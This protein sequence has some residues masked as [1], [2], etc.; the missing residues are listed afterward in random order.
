VRALAA[1]RRWWLRFAYRRAGIGVVNRRLL[2]A[3][4]CEV[5]LREYGAV[6]GDNC[7]VHGPLV[8]HNAGEDYR[9]LVVGQN[10]HIGP[11]VVLDLAER[12]SIEDDATLSMGATVLTHADV[13]ERPLAVAHPRTSAPALIKA[14]AWIG[15]NATVLCGCEVGE[16][17]VVGAGAVVR[18][19]VS[20]GEVVAGVP[21]RPLARS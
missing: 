1:L 6:I 18:E 5:L 9:N 4:R 13:G 17:A 19:P 10:V 8:I 14:G 15:A 21:A 16:Q 20:P 7:V 12:V 3:S 2:L 11:L